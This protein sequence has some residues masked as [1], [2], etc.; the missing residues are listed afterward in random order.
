MSELLVE[1]SAVAGA[2]A[3]SARRLTLASAALAVVISAIWGTNPTALK[4][5]LRGFPPMGSAGIRFA[6]AAIGVAVWCWLT[7][8]RLWPRPGEAVAL[9]VNSGLFIAQIATFTLGVYW[10]TA[11]HSIVLLHT[12]PLFVVALAHL[13]IPGDRA[14][15]WKLAGL[16]AASAGILSLFAGEWGKWQGSQLLGDTTQVLSAF[17]LAVQVVYLKRMVERVHPD[18]AI[19]WQ[20]ASGAVVFLGYS[21]AW[22]ALGLQHPGGV[23]VAAVIYQGLIIGTFCFTVWVWLLRRHRASVIAVF[24]FLG[25]VVGVALST[26]ALPE[27]FTPA[28]GVSAALVAVGVVL[29][30]LG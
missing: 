19:F 13:F 29:A 26:L 17:L 10:G 24:A 4:L 9:S 30:N 1:E 20:M 5:V 28:L 14:T 6:L 15:P 8:T 7:K 25:P 22:E 12:Y 3:P 21:F 2:P 18:R 16:G 27:P 23:A 11:S